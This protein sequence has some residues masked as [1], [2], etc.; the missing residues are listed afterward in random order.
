LVPVFKTWVPEIVNEPL[1]ETE[2]D[3]NW[4]VDAKALLDPE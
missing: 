1:G 3:P 2:A 4:V